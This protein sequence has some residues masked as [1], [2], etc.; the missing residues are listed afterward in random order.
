[1]AKFNSKTFN[2]NA[3]GKYVDT[4]PKRKKT[5]LIKS[6]ALQIIYAKKVFVK[7]FLPSLFSFT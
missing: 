2:P 3:F 6:K 4:I 5:E 7:H 1:M